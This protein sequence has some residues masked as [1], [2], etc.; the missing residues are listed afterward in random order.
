MD[1]YINTQQNR[2]QD[3]I[4]NCKYNQVPDFEFIKFTDKNLI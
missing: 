2:Q 1:K 4:Q 3:N